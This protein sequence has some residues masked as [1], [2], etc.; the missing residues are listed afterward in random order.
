MEVGDLVRQDQVLTRHEFGVADVRQAVGIGGQIPE[1]FVTKP[2]SET[3]A[4][5][6]R[7]CT[8]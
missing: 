8:V 1:Q 4:R 6:S 5:L 3:D 7:A 2:T